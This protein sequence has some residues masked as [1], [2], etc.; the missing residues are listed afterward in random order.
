VVDKLTK[1]SC[2]NERE[3]ENEWQTNTEWCP[4]GR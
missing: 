4:S 3:R 1:V 2:Q